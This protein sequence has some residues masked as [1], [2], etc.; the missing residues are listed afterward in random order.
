[1]DAQPLRKR[2]ILFLLA[3]LTLVAAPHALRLS[4]WV[5]VAVVG[6]AGLARVAGLRAIG[7]CRRAGC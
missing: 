2:S 1:M 4:L 3:G 5:S 7:A 6:A